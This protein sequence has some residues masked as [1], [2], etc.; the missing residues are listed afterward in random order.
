MK[1]LKIATFHQSLYAAIKLISL[2]EINESDNHLKFN[3][4][5]KTTKLL[6]S[7]VK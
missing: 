6:L 4:K 7:K 5:L 2:L 1:K 3:L